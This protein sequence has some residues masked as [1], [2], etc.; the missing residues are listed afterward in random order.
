M[1]PGR[2]QIISAPSIL[3]LHPTGVEKLPDALMLAGLTN[4]LNVTAQVTEIRSLNEIYSPIR[5]RVTRCL[6]TQLINSYSRKLAQTI[7]PVVNNRT[8]AL[9]LGG[10]C[11]IL[12]G[13]MAGLKKAGKFGLLFIDAHA[14]FYSAEASTTGEVA[15]M[16]LAIVCGKGPS[17]LADIDKLRPYVEEQNVIHVGQRDR[18]ETKKYHSPDIAKTA[19]KRFDLSFIRE[20]GVEEVVKGI[21]DHTKTMNLDGYW[22]HFDTDSLS[23]ELNPAVDYRLP[24]GLSFTEVELIAGSL[25]GTG[26]VVGMTVTCFNPE[27]DKDGSIA[28][29]IVD[30]LN[31]MLNRV[32]LNAINI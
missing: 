23:D 31:G 29:N 22:I 12:I 17:E 25:M 26:K 32:H 6:N 28:K 5:D 21:I 15:D 18:D 1:P 13:I 14:D 27:L 7:G 19:I 16:D 2:I 8:F 3:G 24:G 20:N 4:Q 11:S 10:D 30:C 9:T